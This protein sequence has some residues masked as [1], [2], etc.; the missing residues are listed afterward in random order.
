MKF[1]EM[2]AMTAVARAAPRLKE[3]MF[4]SRKDILGRRCIEAENS[5]ISTVSE[6][7]LKARNENS[8]DS[9]F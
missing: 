4:A 7:S 8:M 1:S 3:A 2:R 9:E 6:Y 5:R